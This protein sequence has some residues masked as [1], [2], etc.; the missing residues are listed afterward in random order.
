V[1]DAGHAEHSGGQQRRQCRIAAEADHGLRAKPPH[2]IERHRGPG[3]EQ[4]AGAGQRPRRAAA[5]GLARHHVDGVPGEQA[6][7]A[8]RAGI[9]RKPHAK[10]ALDEF[11]AERL[12]GKQMAAGAAGGQQN[13]G[14]GVVHGFK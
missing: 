5:H 11:D 1:N 3:G 7:V 6:A 12:G 13:Q 10:T 14:R 9:G 2:Q 8:Q 4:D